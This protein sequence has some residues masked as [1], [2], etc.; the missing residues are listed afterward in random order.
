MEG[1]NLKQSLQSYQF[2]R[3]IE[4]IGHLRKRGVTKLLLH[5]VFV[6]DGTNKIT[7]TSRFQLHYYFGFRDQS[8]KFYRIKLQKK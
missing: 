1:I 2:I 4:R 8:L 6:T 5:S 7:Q 3:Y